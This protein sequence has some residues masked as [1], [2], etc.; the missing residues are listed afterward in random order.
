MKSA[1]LVS[2]IHAKND[3]LSSTLGLYLNNF[4]V[5][6][7]KDE[8]TDMESFVSQ[9]QIHLEQIDICNGFYLGYTI[10]QISKEFDL[11]RFGKESIVN[12]ELKRENTG[13]RMEEQLIENQYYLSFLEK[14]LYSFTYVA[15]DKKLFCLNDH[16]LLVETNFS[17]L[18]SVLREQVLMQVED[19]NKLFDPSNYL[20]SPFNATEAFIEGRYFLTNHQKD[21]KR[22]ILK[23][24]SETG[25]CFIS[26]QGSAGTGK[27]LLTYDIAKGYIH[28][29]K[30]TLIFH[31]GNLNEGHRKLRKHDGWFIAPIKDYETYDLSNYDLIVIDEA[32]RMFKGQVD[33]L[34]NSMKNTYAKCIFSYDPEQCLS[35][36]EIQRN[37][38]QYITNQISPHIFKLTENI[39]VSKEIGAFIKNLF[40]LPKKN[41]N[42]EYENVHVQYFSNMDAA[43]GYVDMFTKQGWKAI[44][45]LQ[46]NYRDKLEDTA[47]GVI[48]QEYDHVIAML[49]SRFYYDQ[50]GKLVAQ[51]SLEAPRYNLTKALFQIVTRTRKKLCVVI[52]DNELVLTQCLKILQK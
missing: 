27:T 21:I 45:Y 6:M 32:Q 3:L 12:I 4:G 38:P 41:P 33:K 31:C 17:L 7:K 14:K 8:L 9:L 29:T 30:N 1:N 48:G 15:E 34:L 5:K 28:H 52:V 42:I 51:T 44:H 10:H 24:S 20:V 22:D 37:I 36:G 43:V 23:L 19:I 47:Y 16:N 26:I 11:L 35:D 50:N 39:R 18:I 49:D 2:V 25:P 40:H 46:N 13:K